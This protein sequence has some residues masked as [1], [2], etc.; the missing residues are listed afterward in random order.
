MT[1]CLLFVEEHGRKSC[2]IDENEINDKQFHKI[3]RKIYRLLSKYWICI[4]MI[5]PSCWHDG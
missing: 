4:E 2:Q 1:F 3:I 5:V